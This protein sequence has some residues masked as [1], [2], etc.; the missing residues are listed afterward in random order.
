M[1]KDEP[2]LKFSYLRENHGEMNS[3]KCRSIKNDEKRDLY[4]W[5]CI[6]CS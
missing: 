5:V 4:L 6:T 1:A 2:S 3:N